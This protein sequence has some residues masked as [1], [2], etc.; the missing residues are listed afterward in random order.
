MIHNMF[1]KGENMK[2]EKFKERD[3]KRIGIIVFTIT[4]I[5]LVCGAVLYR[6]FAIFEVKTSQNV[7]KG[8]VEDPGNL[9]FAF[10]QKNEESGDYEIKKDMPQKGSGYYFNS[11]ESYCAVN[12]VKDDSIIPWFDKD[13]WAVTVTGL[14]TSRTK[15]NLYFEKGENL[16]DKISSLLITAEDGGETGLYKVT[17]EDAK[18]TYTD[19]ET[20]QNE[21]KKDELRY[22]GKDPNNY[23]WF[24]HELWRMIGLVNTPEGQRVKL[25]RNE[26]IG[27]FTWD[28]STLE[29]NNGYGIN[30][31]SQ[32]K[33][34]KL[35]NPGYEYNRDE[36]NMLVNNSLYW[37]GMNGKC[38]TDSSI[39]SDCQFEYG[40]KY[41]SSLIDFITWNYGSNFLNEG[42]SFNTYRIYEAERSNNNRRGCTSGEQC[43][44]GAINTYYL[45]GRIGLLYLSDFGYATSGGTYG[46]DNCLNATMYRLF[47]SSYQ[48]CLANNWLLPTFEEKYYWSMIPT[49]E[50]NRSSVVYVIRYDGMVYGGGI[51]DDGAIKPVLYL[52]TDVVNLSNNLGS[53]NSPYILA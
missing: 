1:C 46:R 49:Q 9:Y 29:V 40:L 43:D 8:K 37:N 35:L 42:S 51:I 30:E 52:K 10:Y 47:E 6:T 25:V 41:S 17:H 24:N 45:Q 14:K 4:C 39:L 16:I 50:Y 26:S 13:G 32:S 27:K 12:G 28:R 44:D 15:C 53:K 3:K 20:K 5:L 23:V 11:K 7:I 18:I 34:M 31:W 21:L 48:S 33:I 36:N 19:D 22:A 38:F 2:L